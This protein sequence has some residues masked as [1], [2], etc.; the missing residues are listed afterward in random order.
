MID[1]LDQKLILEL[2]RN[3]RMSYCELGKLLGVTEGTVRHR[4]KRL[5][6]SNII[7]TVAVPN[8]SKLGY[9]FVGIVAIQVNMAEVSK[10]WEILSQNPAVC[11]LSWVTGRYDLIAIVAARSAKE[12]SNFMANE[13]SVIPS[14]SRTETFVALGMA[15]GTLALADT[16]ELV[17]CLDVSSKNKNRNL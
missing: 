7:K 5:T 14:V 10:V 15:K 17:R 3:G 8:M 9:N 4:F 13:L 6:K 1:E 12:F 2:Q 16:T 11:Q